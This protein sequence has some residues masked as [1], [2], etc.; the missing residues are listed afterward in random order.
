MI[1]QSRQLK[2]SQVCV[3][4]NLMPNLRNER[5]CALASVL[6]GSVS[7]HIAPTVYYVPLTAGSTEKCRVI[8]HENPYRRS[9]ALTACSCEDWQIHHRDGIYINPMSSLWICPHGAS[10]LLSLGRSDTYLDFV[11][12]P[13]SYP[14]VPIVEMDFGLDRRRFF[15]AFGKKYLYR[16]GGLGIDLEMAKESYRLRFGV[17]SLSKLKQCDWAIAAAEVQSA[18]RSNTIMIDRAANIKTT[19]LGALGREERAA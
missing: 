17:N 13:K 10:V 1:L 2:L 14:P 4:L 16:W 8:L 15:A 12:L 9:Y 18:I 11:S 7:S 6:V 5:S 19:L 3:D